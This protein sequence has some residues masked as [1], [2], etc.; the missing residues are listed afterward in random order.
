VILSCFSVFHRFFFAGYDYIMF[1]CILCFQNLLLILILKWWLV[2]VAERACS[3]FFPDCV[4]KCSKQPLTAA[5]L[6]AIN[7]EI[8][9][10][11]NLR[12]CT[13]SK[14][15]AK[16]LRSHYLQ[17]GTH[18]QAEGGERKSFLVFK[19]YLH[20]STQH[21]Y[22]K[23]LSLHLSIIRYKCTYIV[24]ASHSIHTLILL[25]VMKNYY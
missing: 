6:F 19:L 23:T 2:A 16:R 21:P 11:F 5:K 14:C 20:I 17:Q 12:I 8:I 3:I 22:I 15:T 13:Q 7:N 10:C 1:V 4:Y 24:Y 18:S 25:L 9:L